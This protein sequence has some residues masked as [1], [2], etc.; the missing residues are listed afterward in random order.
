MNGSKR[1]SYST[2]IGKFNGKL[3]DI[4]SSSRQR[5]EIKEPK[6]AD[7]KNF[8]NVPIIKQFDNTRLLPKY[9][10]IL[11]RTGDEAVVMDDLDQLQQDLEK[12]LCTNAVRTRFFLGEYNQTDQKDS[13]QDKKAHDKTS[14]KRKRP[15][16]KPKFKDVKNGLRV[17]K[18]DPS[19]FY[20]ENAYQEIPKIALPRNDNS[21]KFWA[22]I[23]PY[24]AAVS[25]DDVA[26]LDTLIQ[27]FSKD[28]DLRIPDL[29]EHYATAWS[30]ELLSDEQ[31]IGKSPTKK[32]TNSDFKKNGLHAIVESIIRNAENDIKINKLETPDISKFKHNEHTDHKNGICLEKRLLKQFIGQGIFVQDHSNKDIP[33]DEI[34]SEIKKCQ[35][36]LLTVNRYNLEELNKLRS[37]V[38]NDI[39]CNQLKDDLD[40]I[41]K[42][43]LD[44]Y[45]IMVEKKALHR[46]ANALLRQ[47]HVLNREINNMTDMSML[48]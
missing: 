6:V 12:L 48:Y 45:S 13:Q 20:N 5:A 44:L 46:K 9:T 11:S 30:D 36:E 7:I 42:E 14:L 2:K 16:E 17:V 34:L 8:S 47:Q 23:E 4:L 27:E 15:D 26:F 39:H 24:C 35:Q 28:I 40:K 32:T 31:N 43:I 33:E 22:S 37:V 3:K 18:K 19:R 21:D 10:S 25:N 29:G 38:R 1:S 41:D